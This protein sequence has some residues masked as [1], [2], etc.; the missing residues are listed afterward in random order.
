MP[1]FLFLFIVLPILELVVLIQ[2]GSAIGALNTVGLLLLLTTIVGVAL[3]R[4]Q[5]L[6]TLTR[7]N[8]RLNSGEVPAK[9]MLEGMM[10]AFGGFL[11][12][13]PGF[14]TDV[15]GLLCLLPVVRPLLAALFLKR[16]VTRGPNTGFFFV[17]GR[18]HGFDGTGAGPFGPRHNPDDNTIEGEYRDETDRGHDRI[19]KK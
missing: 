7:A 16:M 13:I 19:E 4:R 12:L 3:I 18:S 11:L 17:S 6:S 2:V 8:R 9:E 14:I 1:V 10:L 15:V 5:G